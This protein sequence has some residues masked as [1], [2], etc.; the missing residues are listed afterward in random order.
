M[1]SYYAQKCGAQIWKYCFNK[2]LDE[3]PSRDVDKVFKA[4][5]EHYLTLEWYEVY[6]FIEFVANNL[7]SNDSTKFVRDCNS[8]LQGELSAYRFVEKMLVPVTSE[9]EITEIS[10]AVSVSRPFTPHLER[11]LNLLADRKSPDYANI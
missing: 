9:Q 11:A 7:D 1:P 8:V 6:D 3:I 2:L 4:I 10:E 5:Q